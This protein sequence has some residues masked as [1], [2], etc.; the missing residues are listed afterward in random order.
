MML[1]VD[2]FKVGWFN[3]LQRSVNLAMNLSEFSLYLPESRLKAMKIESN[4]D[5]KQ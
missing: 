5:W 4:K 2:V 1:I 3:G